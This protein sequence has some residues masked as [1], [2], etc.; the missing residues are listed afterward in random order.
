MNTHD[1]LAL[2]PDVLARHRRWESRWHGF[3]PDATL[4]VPDETIAAALDSLF[5]RLDDNYPFFHPAYAGQ[6][7]KPPHPVAVLGYLAAQLVNPN[8]HALDGGPA[9]GRMEKEV[10]A[11]IA[12]MF[13]W[14]VH[15]GHLTGGGTMA[16]IEALW[17]A[18]RLHPDRAVAVSD[19]GHYTHRRM[20][21]VLGIP[22]FEVPSDA[23]GRMSVEALTRLLLSEKIGTVVAT[24]GTTGVGALDPLP[25]ILRAARTHGARVHADAAYG[26]FF[27]L[28]AAGDD[29]LVRADVYAAMRDCDSIV[30]DPHKHGLQPYG[31][32]CVLFADPAVGRFYAHDSP[33]TYFTSDELHL[34]EISLECSRPG[35]A[36]SALWMTLEC[37]PLER[38]RGLGPIL[39]AC[40]EAALRW[41]DL[42]RASRELYL[43]LEPELDIVTY[44]AGGEA[45][46]ASDVSRRS[47]A[48][49][50]AAMADPVRPVYVS[51]FRIRTA[52][53][54]ARYP[55]LRE[56]QEW[57]TVLRSVL[58]K[59]E[60]RT[61]VAQLHERMEAFARACP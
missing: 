61:H 58:M 47:R 2:L 30:I 3:A 18:R 21:E 27:A 31:C 54:R 7:L 41:A 55:D 51:T 16:N 9:T 22:C 4:D 24:I 5:E 25:D 57:A 23:S 36:A 38:T 59:P 14:N 10:T 37:L 39:T 50:A 46:A 49:F 8:N 40:R 1:I 26:G 6:M 13:G 53:L 28:L 43:V 34:G 32:G 35:A 60:H 48:I 20:C 44:F 45:A 11:R 33:Y 52:I 29:A 56:D 17:V 19:Q 12:R 42:I 15:L